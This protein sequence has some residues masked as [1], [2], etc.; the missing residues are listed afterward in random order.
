MD[1][2]L[3]SIPGLVNRLHEPA[4]RGDWQDAVE[5]AALLPQQALPEDREGL[6]EHLRS[7][8]AAL[9]A[10]KASRAD[11]VASLSRLNAAANFNN[12]ALG[13]EASR[14]EFGGPAD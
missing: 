5:M 12:S 1:S 2:Q 3:F 6:A 11:A 13:H 9:I 8:R 10:A 4:R 7:L 14:Q